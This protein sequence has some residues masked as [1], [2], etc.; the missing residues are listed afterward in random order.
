MFSLL[1]FK[2]SIYLSFF[3]FNLPFTLFLKFLFHF[4]SGCS[5]I[6][7]ILKQIDSCLFFSSPFILFHFP[8]LL[9][10]KPCQMFNQLLLCFFVFGLLQVVLL[11]FNDFLPSLH[12]LIV[13]HSFNCL[14]LCKSFIQH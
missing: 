2:F 6:I 5:I 12:F 8:L 14:F 7:N 13:L 10:F 3:I 9:R 11:K 1:S 4:N